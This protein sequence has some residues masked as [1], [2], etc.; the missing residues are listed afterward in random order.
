MK[1]LVSNGRS[2]T[3]RDVGPVIFELKATSMPLPIL[4]SIE[5]DGDAR[6]RLRDLLDSGRYEKVER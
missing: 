3:V 5:D 4:N 2:L 1:L 6:A